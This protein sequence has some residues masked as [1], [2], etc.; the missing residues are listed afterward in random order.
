MRVLAGDIGGTKTDLRL[1]VGTERTQL[2]VEREQ[3]FESQAFSGL[4]PILGEFLVGER[5]DAAAFGVAGAVI[6]GIC[7]T[8]NLPWV[9]TLP[10]LQQICG[11]SACALL[12]DLQIAALGVS[13]VPEERKVWLQRAEV[14]P[15]AP[16]EL[17]GVGTGFGR[18]FV[19]PGAGA[20]AT[21]SG[22]ANFAPRNAIERRLLEFLTL[23]HDPVA[24]EHVLSGPALHTLYQF[25]VHEGLSPATAQFEI[26][27]AEDPSAVIGRLGVRDLDPA[28]S[29]AV[30]LFVDLLGSEL[31]NVAL[32][33]VPRAGLY[34]WGG[35]ARKL[36]PAL[37]QGHLLDA[38]LDKDR[39]GELLQTIPVALLD[40]AD[41]GI[42]GALVA[43]LNALPF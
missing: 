42:H 41:L 36:R 33:T 40:E 16:M 39:M 24:V 5:V 7:R 18:S 35:V 11:T 8:T 14:D 26:D 20:F 22:H 1:Y 2:K 28:S 10:D 38:F 4:T 17:V 25:I 31:G 19:I 6:K 15:R 37:E 21:E 9:V 3:R 43:A 32:S 12:N 27:A 30:G 13:M 23:R 34:L 29:A